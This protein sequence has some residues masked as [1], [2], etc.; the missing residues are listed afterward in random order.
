MA[1]ALRSTGKNVP[2]EARMFGKWLQRFRG[3]IVDGR[4]FMCVVDAK[5][6]NEWW[7]EGVGGER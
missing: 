7:I 6:G 2:P 1:M 4:R 5:R 3:R